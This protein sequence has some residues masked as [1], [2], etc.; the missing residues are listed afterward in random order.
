MSRTISAKGLAL[1]LVS[2]LFAGPALARQPVDPVQIEPGAVFVFSDGRAERFVEDKGDTQVWA[3]RKG[4]E[5]VRSPNFTVPILE[6][7]LGSVEGKR[8]ISGNA[9]AIWPP[10]ENLRSRF[11]VTTD[12][13]RDKDSSRRSLQYWS[14]STGKFETR[15]LPF[16]EAEVIPVACDRYSPSNMNLLERRTWLWAPDIGHYVERSFQNFNTGERETIT[17]CAKIPGRTVTEKR[18]DAIIEQGC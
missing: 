16:G 12:V 3:T 6:W 14:C 2:L 10:R 8:S 11:R 1:S 7:E 5:F 13:T 17:L 4:R 9:D 15:E 18:I